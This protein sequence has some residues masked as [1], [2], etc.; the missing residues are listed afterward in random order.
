VTFL[1]ALDVDGTLLTYDGVMSAAT[2]EALAA[3]VAAGHHVVLSTGR[4]VHATAP[5]WQEF[6][7]R[8]GWAVCSNGAVTVRIAPD[9]ERGWE[10]HEVITFDPRYAIELVTQA[11]PGAK[12][13]VEVIGE[14]FL[15]NEE[16]PPGELSGTCTVVPL[17]R[18]WAEPVTRVAVRAPGWTDEE[19]AHVVKRLGL[20]DVAYAIG[21]TA[22][23]DI[24]PAGTTKASALEELRRDLGV[25]PER[26]VAVGDGRNDLEMLRWAARGVAMG[27]APAEVREAADEVT[28][29]ID[30]DGVV[31]VLRSLLP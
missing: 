7:L 19:F 1:V 17:E 11:F 21:Y 15:V 25:H 22:W 30:D 24:A 31:A 4:S 13:A 20:H 3:L 2:R 16:F 6:G 23:L 9:L 8:S 29:T 5:V 10:T 14:G 26:T 27:H 12:V 18:L 28:G